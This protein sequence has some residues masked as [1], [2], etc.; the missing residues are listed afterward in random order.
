MK[1]IQFTAVNTA[2]LVDVPC[3][4]VG[5]NDV[6]VKTMVSTVSAGTERANIVG[7][8]NTHGVFPIVLGYS[9]AGIVEEIGES[10]TKVKPGDRV[11]MYWS[12]H[13]EY[14][15]LPESQVEKLDDT[16]S[17]EEGAMLF[18]ATFPLA[19]LRKTKLEIGES[20]LV[21]G[22]GILGQLAVHLSKAAGAYPVIAA[23]PVEERRNAALALG[24]DYAFDPLSPDFAE[25]VK[26][27][28][29]GGVNTCIEVTGVGAGFNEA[30][31]CMA[32]FGRV[33]LLGC[34]RNADFTVD[35]YHKIHIPGITVV[36]A[37]TNAR[38]NVESHAGYFTH[39]D[40]LKA[41]MKLCRGNR[42]HLEEMICETH[43]PS[44]APE[45]YTRLVK[46]RNFPIVV[47][48]DWRNK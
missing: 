7:S 23:D 44:D 4:E 11:V 12:T 14:N 9:S 13:S 34:T 3:R 40:D 5:A 16:L 36:G 17:L 48:F 29:D 33:A 19:A 10:V 27:V 31:D 38:P 37:H 26:E 43:A 45:V 1:Q 28:T 2:A 6:R 42:I 24:A 22:L 46:D 20:M 41:L 47:Q 15:V 8:P 25:K 32:K 18:I 21:M 39:N 35:Y 30:L